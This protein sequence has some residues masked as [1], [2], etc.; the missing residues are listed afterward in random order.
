[1]TLRARWVTLRSSLGDAK[2]SLGDAQVGL[3]VYE[4]KV[5]IG[6]T[7]EYMA[8]HYM[9]QGASSFLPCMALAP[10]VSATPPA[11]IRFASC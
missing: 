4:S 6:A 7:P 11:S 9:L 3:V 5:P 10:Q 8:G 1:V 2:S